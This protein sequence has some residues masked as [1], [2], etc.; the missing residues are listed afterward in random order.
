MVA[1]IEKHVYEYGGFEVMG[2]CQVC[3]HIAEDDIHLNLYTRMGGPGQETLLSGFAG[4]YRYLKMHWNGKAVYESDTP[5][6]VVYHCLDGYLFKRMGQPQYIRIGVE[7]ADT[8]LL[9]GD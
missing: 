5:D 6:K 2:D 1:K 9:N 7:I 3:G 4:V 8:R